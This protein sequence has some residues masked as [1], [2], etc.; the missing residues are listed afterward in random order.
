MND[1]FVETIQWN[2]HNR[3]KK[4]KVRKKIEILHPL[5]TPIGIFNIFLTNHPE[6]RCAYLH[7]V[8]CAKFPDR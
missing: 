7:T 1:G 5:P 8:R 3:K 4:K 6:K 2:V